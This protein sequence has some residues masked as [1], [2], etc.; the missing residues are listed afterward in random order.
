MSNGLQMNKEMMNEFIDNIG[1]TELYDELHDVYGEKRHLMRITY[2]RYLKAVRV[3]LVELGYDPK[4]VDG[5]FRDALEE[6]YM[7]HYEENEKKK[8][9]DPKEAPFDEF[10]QILYCKEG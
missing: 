2:P 6:K 1:R 9:S 3:S 5:P 7:N 4:W 8:I 10:C